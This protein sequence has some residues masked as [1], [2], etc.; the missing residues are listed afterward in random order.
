M[1]RIKHVLLLAL[2]LLPTWVSSAELTERQIQLL[3]NNCLQ[4]HARPNIG[5]PMM[6]NPSDWK[7]RIKQS[8]DQ[9]AS[10]GARCS[11]ALLS[12]V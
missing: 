6:G 10:R 5:A 9:R 4:C 12:A 8:E 2:A 3:S 1:R 11:L 7:E